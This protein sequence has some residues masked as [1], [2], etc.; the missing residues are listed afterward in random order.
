MHTVLHISSCAPIII[1]QQLKSVNG[2]AVQ[3]TGHLSL[4]ASLGAGKCAHGHARLVKIGHEFTPQ[5][6]RGA[7]PYR[8]M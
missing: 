2:E 8:M 5:I 4:P 7:P 6:T 3:R 1:W